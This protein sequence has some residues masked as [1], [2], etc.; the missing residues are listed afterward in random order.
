[1]AIGRKAQMMVEEQWELILLHEVLRD[2]FARYWHSSSHA[3]PVLAIRLNALTLSV[4]RSRLFRL[5]Y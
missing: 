5:K 4:I 1:M 3:P 2:F